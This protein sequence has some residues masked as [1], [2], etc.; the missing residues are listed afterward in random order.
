[1]DD[2]RGVYSLQ[3]PREYISVYLFTAS[4]CSVDQD[5]EDGTLKMAQS[6]QSNVFTTHEKAPN[7]YLSPTC[8]HGT[9]FTP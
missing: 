9:H 3:L 5:T 7:M 2:M 6:I 1:M 4:S 8:M